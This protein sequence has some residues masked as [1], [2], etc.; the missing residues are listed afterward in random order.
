MELSMVTPL[1][2]AA[3]ETTEGRAAFVEEHR[4]RIGASDLPAILGL[5]RHRNAVHVYLEKLGQW[6]LSDNPAL[7]VGRKMEAAIAEEYTLQTGHSLVRPDLVTMVHPQHDWIAASLDWVREG[8]VV[9]CKHVGF[10]EGYGRPGTDEIPQSVYAQVQQ[11]MEVADLEQADVA[12]LMPGGVLQVYTVRRSREFFAEVFPR[13]EEFWRCVTARTVPMVCA[14]TP[15]LGEALALAYP[16]SVE[17]RIVLD[18][19]ELADLAETY[20]ARKKEIKSLE[21]GNEAIKASLLYAMMNAKEAVVG[22]VLVRRGMTT[23]KGYEVKESTY[24]TFTVMR[25]KIK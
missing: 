8:V 17:D 10:V 16:F 19:P 25:R 11:Q 4:K 1:T 12:A 22:G 14:D 20:L 5:S 21:E 3:L 2:H 18:D 23:R 13:L 6:G 7:R 24:E 15:K 9:E